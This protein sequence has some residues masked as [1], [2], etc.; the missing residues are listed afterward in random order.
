METH[1][2]L[3]I[4][5]HNSLDNLGCL[6]AIVAAFCVLITLY[7]PTLLISCIACKGKNKRINGF[8]WALWSSMAFF[9]VAC[10]IPLAIASYL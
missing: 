5:S 9:V 4:T 10:F 2:D 6:S 8:G 1:R 7:V 3:G